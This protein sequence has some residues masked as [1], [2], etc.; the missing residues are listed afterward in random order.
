MMKFILINF[1]WKHDH[2]NTYLK[3]ETLCNLNYQI[4][5]QN[6]KKC[7][8]LFVKTQLAYAIRLDIYISLNITL[9]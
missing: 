9:I 3:K 1:M 4:L 2:Y 8:S 7:L 5:I 6:N